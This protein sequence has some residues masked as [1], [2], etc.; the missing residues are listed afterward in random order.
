MEVVDDLVTLRPENN[1]ISDE[2]KILAMM[3]LMMIWLEIIIL[4]IVNGP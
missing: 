1:D 3:T 2:E 4:M